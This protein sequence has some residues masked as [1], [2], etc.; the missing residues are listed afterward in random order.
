MEKLE[1]NSYI[2]GDKLIINV[3]NMPELKL[4]IDDVMEKEKALHEAVQRLD[5]YHLHLTFTNK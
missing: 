1:N 5:N 3:D 4:L 2:S